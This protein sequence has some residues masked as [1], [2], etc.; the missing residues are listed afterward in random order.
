VIHFK[1]IIRG[2]IHI[3]PGYL[4]CHSHTARLFSS[5]FPCGSLLLCCL[6]TSAMIYGICTLT[7]TTV[8]HCPYPCPS[9]FCPSPQKSPGI[10]RAGNA[11][12]AYMP[13]DK[14]VR[15]EGFGQK[16]KENCGKTLESSG[17]ASLAAICLPKLLKIIIKFLWP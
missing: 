16:A 12:R 3:F 9:V 7:A 1:V 10:Y 15:G 14:E 2:W 6:F 11:R 5:C 8:L 4:R 17:F 13:G